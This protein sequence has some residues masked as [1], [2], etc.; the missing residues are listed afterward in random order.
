MSG[1]AALKTLAAP[2]VAQATM[3]TRETERALI[4][5]AI[6]SAELRANGDHERPDVI[7][8]LGG[9][10]LAEHFSDGE[11][12]KAWLALCEL[13]LQQKPITALTAADAFRNA[14]LQLSDSVLSDLA[15]W[16]ELIDG[17]TKVGIPSLARTYAN[18]IRQASAR[19]RLTRELRALAE[20]IEFKANPLGEWFGDAFGQLVSITQP[21]GD[22]NSV[23]H[24]KST[25]PTATMHIAD[26][27]SAAIER[28][29]API[30]HGIPIPWATLRWMLG[31]V[32]PAGTVTMMA[33]YPSHGKST[34]A[35]EFVRHA[36]RY[37]HSV[38]YAAL[39]T[40]QAQVALR[41]IAQDGGHDASALR[42]WSVGNEVTP[43]V[44][45]VASYPLWVCGVPSLSGIVAEM[46]KLGRP[47]DLLVID[48]LQLV[49]APSNIREPRHIVEWVSKTLKTLAM[50]RGMHV[51]AISSVTKPPD[52]NTSRPPRASQL[53]E[54]AQ[55]WFDADYCFMAHRPDIMQPEANLH[56]EKAR[57]ARVGI[58][59]MVFD[60]RSVA[61]HEVA[62]SENGWSE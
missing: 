27:V 62:T 50:V 17:F 6:E 3:A 54:S 7:A 14:K 38:F 26:A 34:M 4:G 11:F 60:S 13:H 48:Y 2:E 28:A 49:H 18:E 5:A 24:P 21:G 32:L 45:R 33:G 56:V 35:L 19:R 55:L 20:E 37:G 57:D 43:T 12:G 40:T 15:L 1:A 53:R 30:Q 52:G 51:L 47:V 29:T 10:E 9:A 36:L 39:E 61:F 22:L 44:S 58:M 42:S 8:M 41:L 31:D 46:D 59:P 16:S 25:K 23:L